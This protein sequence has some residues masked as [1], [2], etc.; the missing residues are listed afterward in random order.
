MRDMSHTTEML[1]KIYQA[2]IMLRGDI[3][4]LKAK[5]IPEAMPTEEERKNLG[6]MLRRSLTRC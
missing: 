6:R 1:E 2:I 4:L 3:D 5:L